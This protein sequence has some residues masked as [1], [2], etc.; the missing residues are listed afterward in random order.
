MKGIL[1]VMIA[2]ITGC[3]NTAE[4]TSDATSQTEQ[5]T[6]QITPTYDVL[7]VADFKAKMTSLEDYHLVDVRTPDEVAGGTIENSTNINY[8]T[9]EFS[10]ELGKLDKNKPLML[11]CRSGNRSGKASKIA[12]ELGFTEIYDL[13]G[14]FMAWSQN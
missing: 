8:S 6:N 1:I 12:K 9:S 10:T 5:T 2:L 7:N 13:Q 3:G 14:G 4:S 11:F